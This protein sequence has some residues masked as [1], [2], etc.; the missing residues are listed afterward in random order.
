M[1]PTVTSPTDSDDEPSNTG[2]RPADIAPQFDLGMQ[3]LIDRPSC[4]ATAPMALLV[5]LLVAPGI[6][7]RHPEHSG[8]RLCTLK[9]PTTVGR[10]HL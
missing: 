6:S 10:Y 5:A 1:K 8:S 9:W 2:Q 4:R 3:E 7:G